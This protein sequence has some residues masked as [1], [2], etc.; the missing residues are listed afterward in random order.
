M[1]SLPKLIEAVD[2][3]I[4]MGINKHLYNP[5]FEFNDTWQLIQ[6]NLYKPVPRMES[7]DMKRTNPLEKT[8]A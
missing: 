6:N 3:E 8:N 5:F 7:R 1:R 4:S 2:D